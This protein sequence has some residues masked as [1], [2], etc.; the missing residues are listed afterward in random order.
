[1]DD[2]VDV[3]AFSQA[4]Y[5]DLAVG[6]RWGPFE[7]RLYAQDAAALRG[8]VGASSGG[9]DGRA[10]L[11]VLPLLTLRALRRALHG[12]I[13]GGV[14][15]GQRFA[16]MEALPADAVVATEVWVSWRRERPGAPCLTTFTFVVAHAGRPKAMVDWTIMAPASELAE[17]AA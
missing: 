16:V 9:G 5:A 11:G 14:L 17:A 10:P 6:E 15:M 12:I 8:A 7:D 4:R 3:P 1:V 13:P 2:I